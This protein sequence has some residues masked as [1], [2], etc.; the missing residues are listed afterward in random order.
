MPLGRGLILAT[1]NSLSCKLIKLPSF[2]NNYVYVDII[3]NYKTDNMYYIK[4][5]FLCF[6]IQD[7]KYVIEVIDSYDIFDDHCCIVTIK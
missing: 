7:G 3:Y 5:D 2:I 6:D 1:A 4:G